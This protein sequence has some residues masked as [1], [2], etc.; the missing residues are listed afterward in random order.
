MLLEEKKNIQRAVVTS[1]K[2]SYRKI[3]AKMLTQ[4]ASPESNGTCLFFDNLAIFM[5]GR[6]RFDV[7]RKGNT[8]NVCDAA[9]KKLH[10]MIVA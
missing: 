8:E 9:G 7:R 1:E 2:Q 3:P 5:V 10:F 6:S 4:I